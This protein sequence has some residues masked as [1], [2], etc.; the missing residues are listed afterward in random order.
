MSDTPDPLP[1][2]FEATERCGSVDWL[3]GY[4]PLGALATCIVKLLSV[5]VWTK[6]TP[7]RLGLVIASLTV[8]RS[9]TPSPCV[10]EVVNVATLPEPVMLIRVPSWKVQFGLAEATAKSA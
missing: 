6:Y 4:A 5:R 3:Y 7:D 8:T 10:V 1:T 2:W 9:P